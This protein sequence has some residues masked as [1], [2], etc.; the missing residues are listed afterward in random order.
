[1]SKKYIF[2]TWPKVITNIETLFGE[3]GWTKGRWDGY[4]KQRFW[5]LRTENVVWHL[6]ITEH[7]PNVSILSKLENDDRIESKGFYIQEF[8]FE[9]PSHHHYYPSSVNTDDEWEA[10]V[11]KYLTEIK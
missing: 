9:Q 2:S 8:S 11:L 7:F 4:I 1:M 10:A 6:Y 3:R 5:C